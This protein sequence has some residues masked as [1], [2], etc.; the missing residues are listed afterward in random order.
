MLSL[1]CKTGSLNFSIWW[2]L[3]RA[4]YLHQIQFGNATTQTIFTAS[5]F[6]GEANRRKPQLGCTELTDIVAERRECLREDWRL[7]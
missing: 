2:R 1:G 5:G 6:A 4:I 7:G 3:M